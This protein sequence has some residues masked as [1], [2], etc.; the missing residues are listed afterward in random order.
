M[1]R[2][3]SL[4]ATTA[5]EALSGDAPRRLHRRPGI[6]CALRRPGVQF[7][8][9]RRSIKSF[10][11]LESRRMLSASITAG[12]NLFSVENSSDPSGGV[13]LFRS[14][15]DGEN[16]TLLEHWASGG[17]KNL[18]AYGNSIFFAANWTGTTPSGNE[19]WTS[20]GT[21]AGT[22]ELKNIYEGSIGSSPHDFKSING[23]VVFLATYSSLRLFLYTTDGTTAGTQQ[24]LPPT[25]SGA[26]LYFDDVTHVVVE[27]NLLFADIYNNNV[28]SERW[29]TDGSIART[30]LADPG[31]II[32]DGVLEV[33]GTNG[34]DTIS[35]TSSGGVTYVRING[36]S[37]SFNNA[38][39][40]SIYV[41]GL[42]GDDR[43]ELDHS[44]TQDA[45]VFGDYGNDTLIGGSGNDWIYGAR[46]NDLLFGGAGTD[47]IQGGDGWNTLVTSEGNDS[48]SDAD[49]VLDSMPSIDATLADGI[50][51]VHGT[52]G[53]DL[54]L[55]RRRPS[56]PR[57][58]EVCVNGML[59]SYRAADIRQLRIDSGDQNDIVSFDASVGAGGFTRVLI[60]GAGDDTLSG[61]SGADRISGGDGNDWINGGAG[62]DTLYGD[63]NDDRIFGG[64][65]ADYLSG[66]AG[67]NV[68]RAGA[69][70]DK[71]RATK[72]IDDFRGN[73]GDVITLL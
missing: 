37:S 28:Q 3:E 5:D 61:S 68:L 46:G 23:H 16:R 66:G 25:G 43:I 31:G 56:N 47:T 51:D 53:P 48:L 57:M 42:K 17:P 21:P 30:R 8:S 12:Q 39:F 65:G 69:G 38:D 44:V 19:P 24:L 50:F 49:T 20:N 60:G 32:S 7:H 70:R 1:N 35:L 15:L 41:G 40:A 36:K 55:V 67:A 62:N 6:D 11:H 14:D 73:D 2:I 33:Y 34:N 52:A 59:R 63:A 22:F 26:G 27:G 54:I 9:A 13:D 29:Q 10:E 58:I 72:L 18:F 45:K 64:A 71:I 4:D